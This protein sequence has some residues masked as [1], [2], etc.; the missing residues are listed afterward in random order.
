MPK[1]VLPLTDLRIKSAKPREKAYKLSDGGGLYLEVTAVGTKLWRFAYT[2]ANGK[3]NRIALGA[4]PVVSLAGAREKRLKLR[5][6]IDAGTDPAQAKRA[7]KRQRTIASANTFE[8]IA[9]EWIDNKADSWKEST[10]KHVLQ[11]LQ[12]DIFPVLGKYPIPRSRHPK[13]S[14]LCD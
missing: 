10:A 6:Q 2:Q 9:R 5:Q 11:R 8:V 7:D 13:C 3:K 1:L 12:K 14:M 4:Y